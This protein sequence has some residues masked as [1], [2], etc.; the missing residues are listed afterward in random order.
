MTHL[1]LHLSR[2]RPSASGPGTR[3]L[4]PVGAIARRA[5]D[6][7]SVHLPAIEFISQAEEDRRIEELQ[8]LR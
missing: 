1:L 8:N 7:F 4:A 3:R 5:R 6:W 2:R